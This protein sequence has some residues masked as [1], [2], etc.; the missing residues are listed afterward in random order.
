MLHHLTFFVN[1]PNVVDK[2]VS[3]EQ[4]FTTLLTVDGTARTVMIERS[5]VLLC[6]SETVRS[7]KKTTAITTQSIAN[8]RCC[9]LSLPRGLSPKTRR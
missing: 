6:R 8:A 7:D 2:A 3:L 9:N 4:S 1:D 5:A